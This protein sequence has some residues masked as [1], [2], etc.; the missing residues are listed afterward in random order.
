MKHL[1]NPAIWAA[2]IGSGI[3]WMC[4]LALDTVVAKGIIDWLALLFA[5]VIAILWAPAA[6]RAVRAGGDE[7]KW[8]LI[9]GIVL[10]FSSLA[11]YRIWIIA[12]IWS[13]RPTWMVESPI[14]GYFVFWQVASGMLFLSS[15]SES[16]TALPKRNWLY[17]ALTL[18]V[19]S[20]LSGVLFTRYMV[21]NGVLH[22]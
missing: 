6:F 14:T 15:A 17:I 22:F 7:A 16:D 20:F 19:I 18:A 9:L 21:V 10:I 8:R 2:I 11:A 3:Y 5:V 1:K 4:V 13:G 12:I